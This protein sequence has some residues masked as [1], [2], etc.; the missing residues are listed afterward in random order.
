MARRHLAETP[1]RP[2]Q[3]AAVP[4]RRTAEGETEV[5]LLTS[6]ETRRW[7][8]PKGWPI[9][10]K[11]PHDSAAREA[12]E[13]AGIVGRTSSEAIGS[14]RY[15]KRLKSGAATRCK[16]EVFPLAVTGQRKRWPEKGQRTLRWFTLPEAARAVQEPGLRKLLR[17]LDLLL[18]EESDG[19]A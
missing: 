10:G 19:E 8:I 13:E 12:R 4:Y 9:R 16:V 1:K 14:Y 11:K 2:L 7:V 3:Y 6:R 17:R 15:D 5:L 18:P